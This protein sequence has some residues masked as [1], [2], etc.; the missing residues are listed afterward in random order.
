MYGPPATRHSL[1]AGVAVTSSG[2]DGALGSH[3]RQ[4]SITAAQQVQQDYES[5]S[6]VYVRPAGSGWAET[7][8]ALRG[9][10]RG[11]GA[12][13]VLIRWHDRRRYQKARPA[14]AIITLLAGGA[15]WTPAESSPSCLGERRVRDTAPSR[16][17]RSLRT[18]SRTGGSRLGAA[19][20]AC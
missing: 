5:P 11:G 12:G 2:A 3:L 14:R 10:C 4:R 20:I 16:T 15:L 19:G 13:E 17:T 18:M 7:V 9:P 1:D 6:N 8:R